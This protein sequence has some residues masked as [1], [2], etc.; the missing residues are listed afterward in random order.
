MLKF[1]V[2][3]PDGSNSVYSVYSGPHPEVVFVS[4]EGSNSV[5]SGP[6][7]EFTKAEKMHRG[8]RARKRAYYLLPWAE[9]YKTQFYVEC[10]VP[11]IDL[12]PIR[13]LI[14]KEDHQSVLKFKDAGIEISYRRVD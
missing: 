6:H 1:I 4:P 13:I 8:A 3:S 2:V 9:G 12:H 10:S 11:S 7:P 14:L 5:Y